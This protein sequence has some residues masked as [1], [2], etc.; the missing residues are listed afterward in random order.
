MAFE[1]N[2]D[3][4]GDRIYETG[5]DHGV[6]YVKT[7]TETTIGSTQY[8]TVYGDGVAWNGLTAFNDNPEGADSNEI[9]ADN[10]QYL[11][12]I[13]AEKFNFGI[14]CYTYPDEFGQC[15]GS[16]AAAA[17]VYV[18]Q[19][20]RKS[21]GFTCRTRIGND[22]V[23]DSHGYKLHLCYNCKA[24]P[25]SKDYATINDSPEAITFSYDC[26]TTPE[27]FTV[28][29][30]DTAVTYKPTAHIVIDSTKVD[31]DDL[32]ALL[33]ILYGTAAEGSTTTAVK[34]KLPRIQDVV[35]IFSGT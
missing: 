20:D 33:S 19:Q 30:G 8:K 17:G 15:D 28:G 5:V 7:T 11:N 26:T 4:A 16:I 18:G 29:T 35:A 1:I 9:Y 32:N 2:W 27:A 31:E 34:G 3:K 14:E 23:G 10:I 24:G 25:A 21:F 13:S 6:L 22:E 12:L